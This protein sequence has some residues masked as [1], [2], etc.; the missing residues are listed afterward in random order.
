MGKVN[1]LTEKTLCQN[2]D[3]FDW[4]LYENG[5]HGGNLQILL[6]R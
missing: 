5:Y 3:D 2:N 1:K 6:L 4:T